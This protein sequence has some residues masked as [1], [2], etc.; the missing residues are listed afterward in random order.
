MRKTREKQRPL[1]PQWPDHQLAQE[2]KLISRILDDNPQTLELIVQDLSDRVDSGVGAPGLTA[3]QVLRCAVIKQLHQFSYRKLEFHLVDSQSCQRFCRLPYGASIGKATL[4]ENLGKIEP[5]TGKA[6][7]DHLVLWAQARGL[8][9]GQ[10]IRVDAT[11]VQTNIHYPLDSELLYDG[12]RAV[13]RWLG[14]LRD[15]EGIGFVDH[16]RRAKRRV[17]NIRNRRGKKRLESYRDLIKV[18]SKTAHYAEQML[19]ASARW[20]DPLSLAG[21]AQ[22]AHYLELLH[23]V[24]EQTQRRVLSGEAVAAQEKICSIFE[25]HTDII[26]KSPRETVFGHKVFVSTGPSSLILDCVVERGNPAD[27]NYVQPFLERHRQLYGQVPRQS[28]WDGGF[29]SAANLSWAKEQGVE[30]VA[31][32]KKCGLTVESMVRSSRVYKELK[33]F[34]AGIEGCIGT[35]KHTFGLHRCS[36]KGWPHFQSYVHASVLTYNLV[37]LARLLS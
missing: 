21:A 28:A 17:L 10:R 7:N 8:E 1:S 26:K 3:E 29:A 25:E 31:F 33:R 13:T 5:G 12:I 9:K 2:L 27:S 20:S 14:R 36:W 24:I 16:T 4:A 30:D 19:A 23:K 34:R 6:I 18:A 22:L 11:A 37:V 32:A 15:W 35:L